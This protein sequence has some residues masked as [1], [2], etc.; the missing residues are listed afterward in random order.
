[1]KS[2]MSPQGERALGKADV[3]G[4]WGE[5]F[6]LWAVVITVRSLG[7]GSLLY[8]HELPE[9]TLKLMGTDM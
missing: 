7:V 3:F 4:S 8:L 9:C 6:V 5:F 2:L 1:M